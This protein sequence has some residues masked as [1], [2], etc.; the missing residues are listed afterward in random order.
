MDIKYFDLT[1]NT[2]DELL[3]EMKNVNPDPQTDVWAR[4]DWDLVNDINF[5]STAK[6]C[7]L[8]HLDAEVDVVI[9]LPQW[10]N[11]SS[12]STKHQQWWQTFQDHISAH[13]HKHK[14]HVIDAINASAKEYAAIGEKDSCRTVR[15]EY[16]RIKQKYEDLVKAKDL[17]LDMKDGADVCLDALMAGEPHSS[18]EPHSGIEQQAHSEPFSKVTH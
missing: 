4:I 9:T 17:A 8:R 11:V 1:V 18:I 10:S 15:N 2:P 7:R 6:G 5:K 3:Q 14:N 12:L 13:E 16:L